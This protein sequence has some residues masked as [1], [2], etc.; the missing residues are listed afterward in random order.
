MVAIMLKLKIELLGTKSSRVVMIPEECTLEGLHDV[1]QGLF[2]WNGSHLWAFSGKNGL[3]WELPSDD[4]MHFFG[5]PPK[6]PR[7]TCVGSVLPR[8]GSHLEYIYD[9]GDDWRHRITRM[10]DPKTGAAYGCVKTVGPDGVDDCGGAFGLAD[11]EAYEPT[12]GEINGRIPKS[13]KTGVYTPP[14]SA[15]H[16]EIVT[17]RDVVASKDMDVLRQVAEPGK[18]IPSRE[19]C[20]ERTLN[21]I[22]EHP[23]TLKLFLCG[24]MDRHYEVMVEALVKGVGNLDFPM[25]N[26]V[27]LFEGFP[28]VYVEQ[29]GRGR[30]MIVAPKELR[31]IWRNYC[32]EWGLS[33]ARWNEIQRYASAAVRLYGSI[34]VYDFVILLEKY[35][36]PGPYPAA[37][38]TYILDARS[39]S[40]YASHVVNGHE[41]RWG[42]FD[43]ED[44]DFGMY[45]DF[46]SK[47]IDAPRCETLSK[48]AFLAYADEEYVEDVE[49]VRSL[50]AFMAKKCGPTDSPEFLMRGI[51][52][53]L[54][55]GCEPGEI[56]IGFDK[57][58]F[59]DKE[60]YSEK[61]KDMIEEVRD[62]I[63]L[64][65]YN[66]H[67]Y[68][69]LRER[70][71]RK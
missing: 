63:R 33:H 30:Y 18:L 58:A 46:L 66:G 47:R 10:T 71:D 6:D 60:K 64:P 12:V 41:L 14:I 57:R 67:T 7:K 42:D 17:L 53:D 8:K 50:L 45:S 69:E 32:M 3:R 28:Y 51:V 1:I 24:L 5:P 38:V 9:F 27:G 21:L 13:V 23:E 70:N 26:E 44:D 37:L 11:E 35:G 39:Y 2:D 31:E 54:V 68:Q 62:N 65:I 49:A 16:P 20:I 56:V 52:G 40:G 34:S 4:A 59:P 22:V 29:R 43:E 36:V 25:Q 61:L 19:E 55:C 48:D 15:D